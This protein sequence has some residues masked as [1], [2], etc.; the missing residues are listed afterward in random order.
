MLEV[1]GDVI[2]MLSIFVG[3]V[4]FIRANADYCPNHCS[5]DKDSAEGEQ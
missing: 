5:K 3:A 4:V 1:I 2:L